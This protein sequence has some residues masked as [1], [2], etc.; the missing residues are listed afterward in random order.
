MADVGIKITAQ[1]NTK[2]AF[3]SVGRGLNTIQSSAASVAGALAGIGVGISVGGF[4]AMTKSIVDGLDAMND[5]KD[6]TGASIEN[7]SALE[8]VARRTGA[9]LDVVSTSLIKLNQG[10]N[11]AKP[12]SDTEAAIKAIGLSVKDLKALDPAE[13]FRQVAVAMSGFA[14]DANK[15]R[16]TQELFGK[17]LKEVAPFLKDLAENGQLNATVT[18]AQ[19]DEAE[20]FNKQLFNLQKNATDLGR[21]LVKD[22]IPS[23]NNLGLEMAAVKK[24]SN[25]FWDGVLTQLS[26][27]PFK[28]AGENAAKYRKEIDS[29]EA[30]RLRLTKAGNS[31]VGIDED[32][33]TMRRRQAYFREVELQ[34]TQFN[35]ADGLDAVSRRFDSSRK[36]VGDLPDQSAIKAGAAAAAKALADQNRELAAQ[37]RLIAENGGLTASFAEDWDRLSTIFKKGGFNMEQLTEAQAKLL[38]AQPAIKAYNDAEVKAA[39]AIDRANKA[40]YES[41]LKYITSLSEGLGRLEQESQ[42]QQE[43]I[44]R[45]GLSKEALAALDAEKLE[46][47]AITLDLIAIKKLDKDLDEEQFELY[48]KQSAELRK[49]AALKMQGSIKEAQLEVE[50]QI[51]AERNRGW[52][53]TDNIAREVFTS[54][55]KEGGNAAQKIG[56]TLEKALLSAVYEAT[57]K[58]LVFQLYT[59]VAG[60]GGSVSSLAGLAGGGS[61]GGGV[62]SLSSLSSLYNTGK[63]LF[64]TAG[65]YFTTATNSL[66]GVYAKVAGVP[67]SSVIGSAGASTVAA[68]AGGTAI[69]GSAGI[70]SGTVLGGGAATGASSGAM[71]GFA[72]IP[73]I[74][75]IAMGMMAS[76]NAYDE[77]FRADGS[78]A[79]DGTRF[80]VNDGGVLGFTH[81]SVDKVLQG[82]GIDAKTAGI[83]TG[84]TFGKQAVYSLL[85][86][87]KLSPAGGGITG[88]LSTTGAAAQARTDTK[89]DHRGFLGL[90]SYT[91]VNSSFSAL[92][93]G[94]QALLDGGVRGTTAAVKAYAA[95]IGLTA[96]AVNGFTQSINIDLAGLDAEGIQKKLLETFSGFGDAMI[97]SAY[98]SA[99]EGVARAGEKPSATLERLSSSLGVVNAD[100]KQLGI[101]M[102]PVSV[103]SAGVASGLVDAFGGIEKMQASVGAYYDAFYT[104]AEKAANATGN[105][106]SSFAALGVAVPESKDAFRKLVESIDVSTV[107]GQNLVASL[108]NLAP[109]FDVVASNALAAANRM[110]GALEDYGTSDEVRAF[111]VGMIQKGLADGG[112]NLTVD[113]IA[114]ASR[115]DARALYEQRIAAGDKR[116]AD[117]I[118]AQSKAFAGITQP[119]AAATVQGGSIGV[120]GGDGGGVSVGGEEMSAVADRWGSAADSIKQAIEDLRKTLIET[121][122]DSFARLQA[123]FAIDV[124]RATAGDVGAAEGLPEIAKSLIA[125]GEKTSSS[126]VGQ[127]LLIARTLASLESVSASAAAAS[128]AAAAASSAGTVGGAAPSFS[129]I[130]FNPLSLSYQD[131]AVIAFKEWNNSGNANAAPDPAMLA[132]YEEYLRQKTSGTVGY[133]RNPFERV[134][135]F[136][137][138]TN[139]VPR[140]MLAM[141]HEGEAVVPKAYNPVANGNANNNNAELVAE[142]RA[143][144]AEVAALKL[145]SDLTATATRKTAQVLDAAANGGQPLSTV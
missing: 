103:A 54:W 46:S 124:A 28:T 83:L 65:N 48:K 71:A 137:I 107:S 45:L 79:P 76:A 90:G 104:D 135:A 38:G 81:N 2:P 111:T 72:G 118:L 80:N 21:A 119:K 15:A 39:E 128:A 63:N 96:D 94:T 70:G 108:I 95:A 138:G 97:T 60:G 125:A 4:V 36:S 91:T 5:L 131:Q 1:D 130:A 42:A 53:Q 11:T 82:L 32:I 116:G 14:D 117:A 3:D 44:D 8:D 55:A 20:K 93:G 133:V 68:T 47:Q 34:S 51:T 52:E 13:A 33:A 142:M 69:G 17:S 98:G 122:P 19:A 134:P 99:L 6:A 50:K 88:T 115:A 75:W 106:G 61:G 24:T 35:D 120:G 141:I 27:N 112:V 143:L 101:A 126:A 136:D 78:A 66:A 145:S 37:A 64:T 31:T 67:L 140:D 40:A 23:L 84:S 30:S 62:G 86:G 114:N 10:L 102:L 25:G 113:Q 100:L 26:Q 43:Y 73:V 89:Q 110:L 9:G 92:D 57:L 144:R 56:D 127:A 16:L 49:Q 74:G 41:R 29:L 18:A 58:P 22:L 129:G 7:I 77:G 87:Y 121:G 12:G 123:Q 139:Y 109:A 132:Q 85:G 105:L 59:S